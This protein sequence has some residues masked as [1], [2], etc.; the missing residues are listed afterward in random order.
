[1][2]NVF[3]NLKLLKE[4][5]EMSGWVIDSFNFRFKEQNYIVLVKLFGK[6]ERKPQ[7]ALVKLEFLKEDDFTN[8]LLMCA[9]SVKLFID[10]KTLREYF[11]IEYSENLGDILIQFNEQLA[12]FIPIEV[13]GDKSNAQKEAMNVSLSKSDS[14]DP[15][16]RYCFSVKRNSVRDDGTLGKRSPY[17]DN[18]T[19]LLRPSL[20]ALLGTDSNLSFRYSTNPNDSKTDEVIVSNW[21]RNQNR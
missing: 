21:T 1:M 13:I 20:Y 5:M 14:E 7:Y 3:N 19:R 12:Q 17:N 15:N 10:A 8:S 16:R 2:S 6:D 18:K 9:N 4:D 11:N